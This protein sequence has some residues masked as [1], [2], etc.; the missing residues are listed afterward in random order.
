MPS[1]VAVPAQLTPTEQRAGTYSGKIILGL[2]VLVVVIGA[3]A[4]LGHRYWPFDRNP[5]VA[6]LAEAADSQVTVRGFHHTY[7]PPGCVL[8]GVVFTRGANS[9]HP[10]ITIDKLTIQ[11]SYAGMLASRVSRITAEG[12]HVFIPAFGT[13]PP[14][15]AQRSTTA[16]GEIIA[17]GMTVEFAN[18]KP[19]GLPYHFDI[20]EADLHDVGE[21]GPLTYRL[22]VHNPEPPG[23]VTASGKFGIWNDDDPGQTPISGEYKFEQANLSVYHGIAG[24][25][26][27]VGKFSGKL[28]HIDISGTTDVPDFMVVSGH[29][30]VH[31]KTEFSAY[32]DARHGDTF[33]NRVDAYFR[34]THVVVH[35]S[36]A[37]SAKGKGKTGLIDLSTD[38][39]R[40]ED[41]LGLFVEAPRAPMSGPVTLR[42]HVEIPT[43]SQPFLEKISLKGK[44]GIA[45]GDFTNPDTQ[46]GVNKLSA[47]AR[48]AKDTSDPETVL[49][50][51]TGEVALDKGLSTFSDISFGVPGAAAL[52]HGT[53][54]LINYKIDLRG[55]MKVQTKISQT[56]TGPK[57]LLLKMMDPFFKK[58]KKGEVVP[59]RISGT[60]EKPSFGLDL[61]DK[62]AQTIDPPSHHHVREGLHQPK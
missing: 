37:K 17:N 30:P 3:A 14:F 58:R 5:V 59:V 2:I 22:K 24:M 28:E 61:N 42:A 52:M 27:S 44:F 56:T 50:D 15:H 4:F 57:S 47:G 8:D 53:Y 62:Q 18:P 25:L 40:I 35:G 7:F 54:N 10:L 60:Y 13:A 6:D 9:P 34:K 45:G 36:I 16:I 41:V 1:P 11:G 31:L 49:T 20:H 12:L 51:L 55:Q 33:L 21:N 48:G 23:E 26:S 39:G 29:H 43:S 38:N 46:E 32:V 19:E